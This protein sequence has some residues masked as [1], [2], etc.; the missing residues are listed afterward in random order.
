MRPLFGSIVPGQSFELPDEIADEIE[1]G[2]R[3]A[4]SDFLPGL[5]VEEVS[6]VLE[7]VESGTVEIGVT[8][9]SETT[10]DS[11]SSNLNLNI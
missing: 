5:S 2:V 8:Y 11:Y 10:Q 9:R 3:T 4:F 1:V 6:V 7:D